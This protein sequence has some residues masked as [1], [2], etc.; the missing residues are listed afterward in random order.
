M[1]DA[2][3]TG[4]V[5]CAQGCTATG[6]KPFCRFHW[7]LVPKKLQTEWHHRDRQAPEKPLLGRMIEAVD[8]VQHGERLL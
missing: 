7:N 2:P 8:L 4:I 5:C 6:P 1:T 3:G